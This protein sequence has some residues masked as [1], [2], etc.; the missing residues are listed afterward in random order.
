[1]S[2]PM[3]DGLRAIV[4]TCVFCPK[5]CRWA[6]P[7][8]EA[9]GRETVTPWGLMTLLDD[10][11]RGRALDAD[12]GD[13]W[14]HCTRCGRCQQVCKHHNDVPRAMLDARAAAVE[15]GVSP[16]A[17]RTWSDAA[18]PISPSHDALPEGGPTILLAGW[19]DEARIAAAIEVLAAAGW[20]DLARPRG[21]L[22]DAGHR[23]LNAGRPVAF[24]AA[25]EGL[26]VAVGD[27]ETII[28]LDAEDAEALRFEYPERG[29]WSTPAPRAMHL[30]E[31]VDGRLEGLK[32]ALAG[33]VLYLDACRLG[34]GL[35]IVDPPRAMLKAAIGGVIREALTHGEAGGCCGA[36]AGFAAVDPVAATQVARDA[37]D[38]E[39]D[40]PVV[41]AGACSAHLRAALAP[42]AV[43]SW[44]EV[45]A[46]G[47]PR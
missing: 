40:V 3:S 37:V 32:P 34:R 46:D 17:W 47:L 41:I 36:G 39:P 42:R 38:I 19:A 11:R 7:V 26:A 10:V 12:V 20:R 5:L 44:V 2:L 1:M 15:A 8:A 6:C 16:P 29:V 23:S 22:R 31:A 25:V 14:A 33:D 18:Y 30:I 43:R 4:E 27:A 45:I 9:E 24:A 13:A 28:C 35:G 21:G